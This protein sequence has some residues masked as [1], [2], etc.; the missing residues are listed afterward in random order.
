VASMIAAGVH[1]AATAEGLAA[2][3][4]LSAKRLRAATASSSSSSSSRAAGPFELRSNTLVTTYLGSV[5]DAFHAASR[6][7]VRSV[8]SHTTTWGANGYSLAGRLHLNM[9]AFEGIWSAAELEEFTKGAKDWVE[10]L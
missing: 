8:R 10:A 7:G 2:S 3:R 6:F 1:W 4:L 9:T 5:D